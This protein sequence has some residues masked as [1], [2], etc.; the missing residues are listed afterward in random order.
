[1]DTIQQILRQFPADVFQLVPKRRTGD[2]TPWI[3]PDLTSEQLSSISLFR[4]F[5]FTHI[6]RQAQYEPVDSDTWK[7]LFDRYFPLKGEA[8]KGH[9]VQGFPTACYYQCWDSL[10]EAVDIAEAQT[11]RDYVHKWFDKLWWVPFAASDRMWVV[12]ETRSKSW[13]MVPPGEPQSC[14][15]LAVNPV[16]WTK[17]KRKVEAREKSHKP[18]VN[19]LGEDAFD[20][21]GRGAN[22]QDL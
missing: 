12:K 18:F 22:V 6:F 13:V 4:S 10:L 15:Q 21:R 7:K 16:H 3:L 2:L 14:P 1:M 9:R 11:I 17:N 8:H 19:Y 5:E 20:Q